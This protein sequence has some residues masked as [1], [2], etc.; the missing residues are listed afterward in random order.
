ML[1]IA[2]RG[3]M[4]RGLQNTPEGV[5]VAVRLGA[6]F[7]ELDIV[8]R[9]DGAFHC[10]HGPG[11][12]SPLSHC[13]TAIGEGMGLVA[14]LKGSFPDSDI[15]RLLTEIPVHLPLERVIFASH[16]GGV[17]Q[18]LR[19]I[20]PGARLARF[21]LPPALAALWRRPVWE[22]ALVNQAVLWR[23]LVRALQARG[24]TVC[25]SC[26]WEFRSRAAVE[27]LGVDGAF[28]NLSGRGNWGTL[29][30]PAT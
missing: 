17:L 6:D 22:I 9:G 21:G 11:P 24:L 2:H 14:H 12:G 19:A 23:G 27:G 29:A 20:A 30:N 28:V 7:V 25:A 8:R 1:T 13:L 5:R 10:V 16:R 3:A 4:S 26:V 18:R 15:G